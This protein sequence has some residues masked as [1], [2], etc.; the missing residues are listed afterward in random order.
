MYSRSAPMRTGGRGIWGKTRSEKKKQDA[1]WLDPTFAAQLE[2]RH[3]ELQKLIDQECQNGNQYMIRMK[4]K[5]E[6]EVKRKETI[7]KEYMKH[8]D[9]I[10]HKRKPLKKAE[11]IP[12]FILRWNEEHQKILWE[13]FVQY[14]NIGVSRFELVEVMSGSRFFSFMRHCGFVNEVKSSKIIANIRVKAREARRRHKM[15][16]LPAEVIEKSRAYHGPGALTPANI[17]ILFT[18]VQ[19]KNKY[20]RKVIDF[21][22][23]CELVERVSI[24][25]FQETPP[26]CRAKAIEVIKEVKVILTGTKSKANRF[27]DDKSTYTGVWRNGGPRPL[28]TVVTL[29]NMMDRSPADVRGVNLYYSQH[30]LNPFPIRRG[31]R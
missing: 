24:Q 3:R 7:H 26:V 12:S 2:R 15:P 28:S 29:C 5:H 17:D 16:P 22:G 30:K 11:P 23:F 21:D 27:H 4:Q 25:V 10:S 13:R 14:C 1:Q 20:P 6:M 18:K 31:Q 9:E 8:L 19:R